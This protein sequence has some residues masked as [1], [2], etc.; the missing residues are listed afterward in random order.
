MKF[1]DEISFLFL[2]KYFN[3]KCILYQSFEVS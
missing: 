3:R 1:F 2:P